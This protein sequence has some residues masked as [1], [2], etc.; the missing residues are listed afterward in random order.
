MALNRSVM[1]N[2]GGKERELKFTIQ[3]LEQVEKMIPEGNVYKVFMNP[4]YSLTN[5]VRF[6]FVG[7]YSMDKKVTVEKV[8][9]WVCEYLEEKPAE[10]LQ[11]IIGDALLKSG[12]LGNTKKNNADDNVE[13]D[14][15][16][17]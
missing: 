5:T 15:A 13:D 9:A 4:P 3:A 11:E 7:L 12:V 6:L 2:I 16:G 17:K 14:E 10:E 1:I 8:Q